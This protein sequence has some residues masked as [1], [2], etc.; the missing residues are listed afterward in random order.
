MLH[1]GLH[2]DYHRPS[3]DVEKL[4]IDGMQRIAR[5]LFGL[6]IEVADLPELPKFR[7][8]VRREST[9]TQ[10]TVERTQPPPPGRLGLQWDRDDNTAPGLKVLQVVPGGPAA[11]AGL[12]PAIGC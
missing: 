11:Q 4:N 6:T 8:A 2:S 9:W 7:E 12:R 10:Q 5:L 1:T 3:D